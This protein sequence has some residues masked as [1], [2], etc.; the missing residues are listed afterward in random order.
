MDDQDY[1]SLDL[2]QR[3]I[4]EAKLRRRDRENL[5][6]QGKL[7]AAFMDDEEEEDMRLLDGER[8]LERRHRRKHDFDADDENALLDDIIPDLPDDELLKAKGTLGEWV[9]NAGPRNLV[10]KKFRY[11][12]TMFQDEDQEAI[13]GRKISTLGEGKIIITVIAILFLFK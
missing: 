13:Y 7:P 12:L 10:K 4:I 2:D 3:K 6:R 11:F 5:R 9:A 8:A 1:E